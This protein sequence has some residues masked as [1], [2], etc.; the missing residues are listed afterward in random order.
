MNK[1]L[2]LIILS[3]VLRPILTKDNKYIGKDVVLKTVLNIKE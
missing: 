2:I 1:R 3:K